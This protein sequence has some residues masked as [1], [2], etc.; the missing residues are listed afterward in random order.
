MAIANSLERHLTVFLKGTE[1]EMRKDFALFARQTL[2]KTISTGEGSPN[3]DKFVNGRKGAEEETVKL[4]GVI[5]YKFNWLEHVAVF[6]VAFLKSRW[7]A[8][9]PGRG[10]HYRD[11]YFILGGGKEILAKDAGQYEQI[12]VCNDKPYSRKAHTGS[13]GFAMPRGL[14]EDCR[15]AIMRQFGR[16]L[17]TVE[18]KF[19]T[20]AG[21]YV[22]RGRKK[23]VNA[24][25]RSVG[26]EM[27]YP[28]VQ[29]TVR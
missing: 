1:E 18:L 4:P 21:G 6:A 19:I 28:A 17:M 16:G 20:L 2:A 27:R 15:Q 29:I 13:K 23:R 25:G 14:F 22:L 24:T 5:L 3:Y 8:V 9:G 7:P 26:E 11:S 10:G 12:I